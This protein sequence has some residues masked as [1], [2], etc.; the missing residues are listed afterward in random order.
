M[1][2]DKL[3]GGRNESPMADRVKPATDVHLGVSFTSVMP[4]SGR[5]GG[6]RIPPVHGEVGISTSNHE[7]V[8]G[9]GGNE[10]T[11]FRPEFLQCCHA[12]CSVNSV[13][14][15]SRFGACRRF[16]VRIVS[17]PTRSLL[18]VPPELGMIHHP[19]LG[20]DFANQL[21]MTEKSHYRTLGHHNTPTALVTALMLAAAM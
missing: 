6:F 3:G 12:L 8:G 14:L 11:N 17:S 16:G 9:T 15:T 19:D 21:S 7:P 2:I 18:P 1:S 20:N 4:G 13:M 5:A 10:S